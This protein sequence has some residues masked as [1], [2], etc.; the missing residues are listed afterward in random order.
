MDYRETAPVLRKDDGARVPT[1]DTPSLGRATAWQCLEALRLGVV[2]SQG[3]V[4]YTVGR[5]KP[6]SRFKDI[7]G[8]GRGFHAV[9][10]EYGEGKTHLLD[11]FEGLA[12]GEDFAV[13]R[14]SVDPRE[15]AVQNPAR[16]WSALAARLEFRGDVGLQAFLE[17]LCNS[18]AHALPDGDRFDPLLSPCLFALRSD[19]PPCIELAMAHVLAERVS[20]EEYRIQLWKAHWDGPPPIHLPDFRTLGGVYVRMLGTIASWARDLDGRGLVVML[21]E[22]ERTEALSSENFAWAMEFLRH[23]AKATLS[24]E[25]LAFRP[26]TLYAG[27]TQR[28]R[29]VPLR[30]EE[31]QPLVVVTAMTP[32]ESTLT[33][34]RKIT[35]R[36]EHA[37]HLAPL[38]DEVVRDLVAGIAVLYRA[39]YP[40][41][42]FESSHLDAVANDV[43][44]DRSSGTSSFR[45]T[46]RHAVAHFD[47]I[48][49][50][51]RPPGP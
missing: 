20:L 1:Q 47:H 37:T 22:V 5:D 14:L 34:Y 30:F 51:A 24:D 48:R 33:S 42:L 43:L 9:F 35:E 18:D 46:V 10:G 17:K 29:E 39:A 8:R 25:E 36:S 16:I 26:E 41:F 19:D 28:H 40:D 21:D 11:A 12:R 23:L 49:L 6:L 50:E 3:T 38:G 13:S 32:L 44:K 45:R 27:G 4:H 31:D 15:T 2:P 7:L